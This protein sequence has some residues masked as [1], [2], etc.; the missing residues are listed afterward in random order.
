[1]S[2]LALVLLSTL[3]G[4]RN[5]GD[6]GRQLVILD[7]NTAAVTPLGTSIDP[8]NGT[9]SGVVAL[10]TG[11]G[12]FFFVG[13]PSPETT[14]RL[15]TVDTATGAE[16]SSPQ[17]DP[18][19][20]VLALEYDDANDVLYGLRTPTDAGKQLVTYDPVTGIATAVSAS[21]AP[22]LGMPGGVSALDAAGQRFFFIG[23]PGAETGQRIYTVST[24]T[25]AVLGNPT[26]DPATS[27]L[28]LE[29]DAAEGVLYALRN[30]GDGGK[31][32]VRLDPAT[33]AATAVSASI[34]PPL[35]IPGGTNALDA[36][37]N[38]FFFIGVPS[39]ETDF[40]IYTVD[41]ATGAVPASPAIAGSAAQFYVGLAYSTAAAP[42][43]PGA[44][45]VLIDVR[46]TINPRSK[47]VIPVA[48]LTT[49][50]F[51][52]TTVDPLS[53]RFGQGNAAEAHGRG[54]ISDVDGDG[55]LDLLLH[56]RTQDAAIPCGAT[57]ASL[58]GQTFS[59]Q[60]IAGFDNIT[61][62]GCP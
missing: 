11:G 44:T 59:A 48:I 62:A 61:T 57:S 47:G 45:N 58:T 18:A 25:G 37:G 32:L 14:W 39:A 52:A 27:V 38:R 10:D 21:I 28:G 17:I 2:A 50:T 4:L 22:P 19:T 54:H 7:P 15:Y 3:Y 23:T 13:M 53:V 6:G 26:I 46:S 29:Y 34:A 16:V 12:R 35:G 43:P 1:M 9:S 55:D 24:A 20:S 5:P 40:H 31:Q 51:D 8:P 42:P 30:P 41:T 56:F 49:S 60:A 36:S 33:G